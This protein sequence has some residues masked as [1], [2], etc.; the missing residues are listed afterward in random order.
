MSIKQSKVSLHSRYLGREAVSFPATLDVGLHLTTPLSLVLSLGV[1]DL[2]AALVPLV[3]SLQ[4]KLSVET[5]ICEQSVT[6]QF[7]NMM[8]VTFIMH[9]NVC[10]AGITVCHLTIGKKSNYDPQSFQNCYSDW[11]IWKN[12]GELPEFQINNSSEV[13]STKFVPGLHIRERL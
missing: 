7:P 3:S 6:D 11:K 12:I 1:S 5:Q 10:I 2:Q 8:N 13:S 9:L 4:V